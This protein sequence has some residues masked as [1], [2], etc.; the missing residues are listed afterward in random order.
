M[1]ARIKFHQ[2]MLSAYE[3]G[4]GTLLR[5]ALVDMV[6]AHVVG[7][8]QQPNAVLRT[9]SVAK[10]EPAATSAVGGARQGARGGLSPLDKIK[11][12][13]ETPPSPSTGLVHRFGPPPPASA[14]P[15]RVYGPPRAARLVRRLPPVAPPAPRYRPTARSPSPVP[16]SPPSPPPPSTGN[17]SGVDSPYETDDADFWLK[18]ITADDRHDVLKGPLVDPADFQPTPRLHFGPPPPA[19]AP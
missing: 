10:L 11:S 2:S 8:V 7:Q 12:R 17:E 14:V 19:F 18:V 5:T 13:Y 15:V 9:G 6:T 4:P 3:D 1:M 16:V